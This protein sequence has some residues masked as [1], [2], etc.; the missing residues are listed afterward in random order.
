MM[1]VKK[2]GQAVGP[3]PDISILEDFMTEQLYEHENHELVR[4]ASDRMEEFLIAPQ[5]LLAKFPVAFLLEPNR[6][7][8][9]N[10]V[11]HWTC[12]LPNRL[13]N[14]LVSAWQRS[15]SLRIGKNT[16][17]SLLPVFL[18]SGVFGSESGICVLWYEK[19]TGN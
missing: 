10:N 18:F 14:F 12:P 2:C 16:R 1:H 13:S 15:N 19:G 6:C 4:T 7:L 5:Y 17:K 9:G 8:L 3:D 11:I